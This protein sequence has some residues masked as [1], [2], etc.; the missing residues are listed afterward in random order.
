LPRPGQEED[1][2]FQARS[3][4]LHMC[5]ARLLFS[6][7]ISIKRYR[8]QH[9]TLPLTTSTFLATPWSKKRIIHFYQASKTV[10]SVPIC[11]RLTNLMAHQPCR[12]VISDFQDPLHLRYRDSYFVHGHV[13]GQPIPFDQRR[14]GLME[15]RPG[16]QTDFCTARLAIQNVSRS[17]EPS[18]PMTAPGASETIRPS[19]F[20]KMLSASLLSGKFFLKFEQAALPISLG[21]ACTPNKLRVQALYELSQ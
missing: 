16:S 13:V 10:S 1:P 2:P 20:S 14:A 21:H 9:R 8:T 17:D 19:H 18:F 12:L 11:H 15:Y 6:L 4:H 3:F 7:E 5:K